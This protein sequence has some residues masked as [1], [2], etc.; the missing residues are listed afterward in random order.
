MSPSNF[1][2][3]SAVHGKSSPGRFQAGAVNK[4]NINPT[5][6]T[7]TITGAA[8]QIGYA[9]APM[10]SHG[11]MF[12]IEQPVMLHLLDVPRAMTALEGIAMEILD[13]AFPLVTGV[14]TFS[15]PSK[16][17]RES[18][19][20]IMV[21]AFPRKKGMERKDLM[22]KNVAIFREMGMAID[23]HANPDI[24]ICVVGN[25]A[26]TNA[27]VLSHFAPKVP[28]KNVTALTR[29]D[30]HRAQ[31]IIAD[32]I[33][34]NYLEVSNV[35]IWGNHSRTMYPDVNHATIGERNPI[36]SVR[37]A[38]DDDKWLDEDY[39]EQ[40]Q[41]RGAAVIAKR[42]ASSAFSAAR[43]IVRHMHSWWNGTSRGQWVSM[44]VWSEGN[45]YG[46]GP[47]LM[48]SFPCKCFG[49]EWMVIRDLHIDATGRKKLQITEAEL[50]EEKKMAF[51]LLKEAPRPTIE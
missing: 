31:R 50:K 28:K 48:F 30:Q 37:D 51:E 32:R 15:D 5:P 6:L 36:Q 24:K 8:G 9:L 47:G 3:G 26:N 29:L 25:P 39:I 2:P 14:K 33:G 38:V 13:G 1:L 11:D 41:S 12:G 34:V 44:G 45:P 17:F 10:I 23:E 43:G 19:V 22:A 40:V 16:A 18:D 4:S 46:I 20:A 21:G 7:V 49:G 27:A 35:I 42:G